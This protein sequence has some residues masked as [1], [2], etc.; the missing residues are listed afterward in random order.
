MDYTTKLILVLPAS[1]ATVVTI[2]FSRRCTDSFECRCSKIIHRVVKVWQLLPLWR[3]SMTYELV[4]LPVKR[5]WHSCEASFEG[6]HRLLPPACSCDASPFEVVPS[7]ERHCPH[8]CRHHSG[9]ACRL[10]WSRRWTVLALRAAS[11]VRSLS[12]IVRPFPHAA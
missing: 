9:L 12:A 7:C 8:R 6:V 4:C 10:R 5:F 3:S 1:C 2:Y 11:L